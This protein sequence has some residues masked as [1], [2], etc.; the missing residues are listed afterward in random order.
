MRVLIVRHATAE[1]ASDNAGGDEA[2]TLTKDGRR[3]LRAA[4]AGLREVVKGVDVLATSP[5]V[6]A[7]ET[8]EMVA[9][10]FDGVK[11]CKIDEL[12]PGKPVKGVLQWLQGQAADAT[13]ALVGHEPQLGLLVSWLLSGEQR[14]F[15]RPKKGSA[16][17]LEFE[18]KVKAGSAVLLWLLTASQMRKLSG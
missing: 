18:G 4:A 2:R 10:A 9:E 7:V 15:V 17:L 12:K 1:D 5:L 11:P 3:K 16:C 14:A 13:V 6:R 8:A